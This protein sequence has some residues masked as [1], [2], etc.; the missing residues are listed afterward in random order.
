[1]K[2]N[3]T[4][5]IFFLLFIIQVFIACNN[6]QDKIQAPEYNDALVQKVRTAATLIPGELPV[7]INYLKYAANI[8]KWKDI[9]EGGSDDA[10]TMA[11]TAFQIVYSQGYVMVD[12]G[13][14]RA[15]HHFFEK[16]SPQP[17][18]DAR[19]N[20]I[21]TSVQQARL[22]LITHEHGD[23]IAGVIRN[24]NNTIPAK[25]ILTKEQV[26]TLIN[27][28]QMPEIKLD[29]TKS[30]EYIITDFESVLP[31]APGI[32][33]IKAPGHTNGEIMI[34]TKLQNGKEYIFTGD[35]SWC[36]KGVQEK[37]QKP[38]SQRKRIGENGENV[39]K[40]LAWLNNRLMKDKMVILVSHDDIMLPQYAAQGLI[41]NDF[42]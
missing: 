14:D 4:Q 34:Y 38:E 2:K 35:V 21:A 15:V 39:E 23:H 37:K 19:A 5:A 40:Q 26:N 3:Y 42:K 1:M 41:G 18:D 29:E 31:V 36:F 11:R 27:N 20:L 16:D 12:A 30:K 10:C 25:T 33:L 9:I 13:M 6:K 28:P 24:A 17:F 32:V 22:I 7:S 8:R